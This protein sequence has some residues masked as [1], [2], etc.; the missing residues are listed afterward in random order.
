[1]I[2]PHVI[3]PRLHVLWA[4]FGS[5]HVVA[6]GVG[7]WCTGGP[8]LL[9]LSGADLRRPDWR[10]RTMTGRFEGLA[11]AALED[12]KGGEGR[13]KKLMDSRSYVGEVYEASSLYWTRSSVVQPQ[14]HLY[15]RRLGGCDMFSGWCVCFS[16]SIFDVAEDGQAFGPAANGRSWRL[17]ACP[18]SKL[19]RRVLDP[20][21]CAMDP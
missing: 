7:S 4:V 13:P 20:E 10:P 16:G 12:L 17:L 11:E 6:V 3:S 9:E 15:D 8:G 19:L 14:V 1:M 5:C 2:L 21:A 18:R